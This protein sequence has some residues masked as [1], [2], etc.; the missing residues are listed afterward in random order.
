MCGIS[1]DSNS[2]DFMV[3]IFDAL[4]K[5]F[6]Q[7]LIY[8]PTAYVVRREGNVLT[9]VCPSIHPS[10]CLST[11]KGGGGGGGKLNSLKSPCMRPCLASFTISSIQSRWGVPDQGGWGY[12]DW[13]GTLTQG[14]TPPQVP[15]VRPGCGYLMG[16][17]PPQVPPSDLDGEYPAW[18][19][20]PLWLT[21]G[22]L[23]KRQSVCLLRSRRRTFLLFLC[24]CTACQSTWA[25]CAS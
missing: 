22:V 9:R 11:P 19:G 6:P 13:G 18:G 15:P 7:K 8:L 4:S 3:L 23:D 1:V 21:D 10:I 14:G 12:P 16:G 17:T 5:L 20:T 24:F 2:T 25:A